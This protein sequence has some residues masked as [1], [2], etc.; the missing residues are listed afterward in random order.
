MAQI[1][2]GK[3]LAA[4]IKDNLHEQVIELQAKYGRVPSLV[5][6]LVGNNPASQSYVK[7]KIKAAEVVGINSQLL[8]F[9]ADLSEETLLN[10]IDRLNNDNAVDGILV[11]LPLP[12][13]ISEDKVIS[14]IAAEKDVD[15]FHPT[16]VAKLWLGEKCL[17]PCTPKGIMRM[18]ELTGIQT[19]G[20]TAVVIGRSNI[21]GK[22]IAKLLLDANATVVM[23]HSR[24]KNMTEIT[25]QADILVVAIGKPNFVTAEYLKPGAVVIDVGINRKDDGKL[26]G[27]VD[28]E[29]AKDIAGWLTP[30]P[31]GVG[32]M[33]IAM[34]MENTV[35]CF[36]NRMS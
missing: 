12:K 6:I 30:V 13:H 32:P 36:I 11:Q 5:V 4:S 24:T 16:N 18:I 27:D 23:T 8:T 34:L 22:P 15:G 10:E 31:G 9:P 20:A 29:A 25:R 14:A 2:D 3:Q 35:E 33:T 28:F 19:S 26:C 7:G 21:V 17:L 1:I